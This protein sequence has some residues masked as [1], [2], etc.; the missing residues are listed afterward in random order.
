MDTNPFDDLGNW[1]ADA[2]KYK[3]MKLSE[4]KMLN[5]VNH[6]EP[7]TKSAEGKF[8]EYS[9]FSTDFGYHSSERKNRKMEA[10]ELGEGTN[11]YFKL[12]KYF[13]CVF[14][15]ATLLSGPALTFY[16]WGM[17]YDLAYD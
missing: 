6:R 14:F 16:I 9:F 4:S 3:G 13:M 15:M 12:M 1:P 2:E 17:E 8:T 7:R 11:L 10:E 5:E